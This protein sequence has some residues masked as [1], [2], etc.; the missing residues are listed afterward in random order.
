MP[1]EGSQGICLSVTL[2][3]SAFRTGKI[4]YPQVFLEQCKYIVKEKKMS[5]Y[6]IDGIEIFSDDENSDEEN[7]DEENSGKENF[8]EKD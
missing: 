2:I 8:D 6:I 7:S 4:Y 1:K 5:K 3:D